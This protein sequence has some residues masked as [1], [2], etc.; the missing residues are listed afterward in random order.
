MGSSEG[1][2]KRVVG[3]R[4]YELD[5]LRGLGFLCVFAHHA[6]GA[7]L[8]W[9]SVDLFFVIS[10]FLITSILLNQ[11]GTEGYFRIFYY[12]R[13][14]RIFP[15]YYLF[16][17]LAFMFF[18]HNWSEH[19]YWYV[20]YISNIFMG[21]YYSENP[22]YLTPMWS[23]SI[24]E[25]FYLLWPV[26]VYFLGTKGMWRLS[27]A[28]LFLAPLARFFVTLFTD[29][30]LPVYT[31]LPCRVD[32]IASGALLAV[33]QRRSSA[34]FERFSQFGPYVSALCAAIFIVLGLTL[35][36]FRTAAHS[37]SFNT[38]GYTLIVGF[39]VG[40][41]AYV[42]PRR[43]NRLHSFLSNRFLVHLGTIS[44]TMYLCHLLVLEQV[45]LLGLSTVLWALLS[46]AITIILSSV[47][48]Y[49]LEKPLLAYK[50]RVSRYT[51]PTKNLAAQL[52][53]KIPA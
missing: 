21:F 43:E 4:L 36:E 24:E 28:L 53:Q 47:S 27:I 16:L 33:L 40:L 25:Q 8:L 32:A 6:V 22:Y 10:G 11:R 30:Y 7:R 15:P 45:H 29:N 20:F 34:Q 48:W 14:L 18:D 52:E 19:W 46:L 5:S 44:Y 1:S 50:D 51:A 26:L 38:F 39:M 31:L 9:T 3:G 23:L 42:I 13:F 17:V 12:R 37:L 2:T 41:V 49:A 35:P